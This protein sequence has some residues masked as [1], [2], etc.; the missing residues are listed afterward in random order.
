VNIE[1]SKDRVFFH[2]I[3]QVLSAVQN[4]LTHLYGSETSTLNDMHHKVMTS[5]PS[6]VTK[7]PQQSR[8]S[9]STPNTAA[10]T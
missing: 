6:P 7:T 9:I 8:Q 5:V 1:P 3:D 2:Q 4:L 10:I